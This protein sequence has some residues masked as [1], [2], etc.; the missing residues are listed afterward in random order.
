MSVMTNTL[1]KFAFAAGLA[2]MQL[3]QKELTPE[4]RE[5][6]LKLEQAAMNAMRY[7]PGGQVKPRV[8]ATLH[9]RIDLLVCRMRW[10]TSK[11][12]PILNFSLMQI[13]DLLE[14]HIKEPARQ[15]LLAEVGEALFNL[16][17]AYP[18]DPDMEQSVIAEG[19]VAAEL[20]EQL[21]EV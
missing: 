21:V 2:Q 20:W 10:K 8:I 5:L 4:N 3:E 7:W 17:N 14:N 18:L 19:I 15:V 12:H 16:H 11:I 13:T 6:L 1:G 9:K